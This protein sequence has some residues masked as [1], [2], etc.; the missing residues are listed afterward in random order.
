M[1]SS[2]LEPAQVEFDTTNSLNNVW[3]HC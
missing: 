3:T 1:S 2:M